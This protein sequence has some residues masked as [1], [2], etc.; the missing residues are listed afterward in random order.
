RPSPRRLPTD[1]G[2]LPRWTHDAHLTAAP[3]TAGLAPARGNP[4]A[5][6][7][8]WGALSLATGGA[9]GSVNGMMGEIAPVS[10]RVD[11]GREAGLWGGAARVAALAVVR[12][13]TPAG[14]LLDDN[15]VLIGLAADAG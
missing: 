15:G 2:A 3:R 10:G 4:T 8:F 12:E 6:A 14:V 13:V 9:P 5:E 11:S 1:A 7:A